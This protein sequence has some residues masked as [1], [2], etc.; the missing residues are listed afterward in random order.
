MLQR[1][2]APKYVLENVIGEV[3]CAQAVLKAIMCGA[4][5][6]QIRQAQ[7]LQVAQSLKLGRVC[8]GKATARESALSK[9]ESASN[10]TATKF[11]PRRQS[12]IRA[13]L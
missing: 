13:H 7:L 2:R 6:D 8:A 12:A 3:A 10:K 5:K 1:G 11:V 9:S 4:R